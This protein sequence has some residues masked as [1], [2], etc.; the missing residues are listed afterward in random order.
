MTNPE[1]DKE[2]TKLHN[3]EY[4]DLIKEIK[5]HSYHESYEKL[6]K[7]NPQNISKKTL[8]KQK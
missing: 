2:I 7:Y 1:Y 4:F 3:K 6:I 8:L 5:Y